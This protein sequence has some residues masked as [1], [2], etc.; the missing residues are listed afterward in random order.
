MP[1]G[2]IEQF[3]SIRRATT[4]EVKVGGRLFPDEGAG[5]QPHL[6]VPG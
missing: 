6:C 1:P 5:S 3:K 2:T 4:E